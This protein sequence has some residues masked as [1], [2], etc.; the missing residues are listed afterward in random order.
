MPGGPVA[1]L[2]YVPLFA[3]LVPTLAATPFGAGVV[4]ASVMGAVRR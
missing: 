1:A 3:L 4:V 2:V